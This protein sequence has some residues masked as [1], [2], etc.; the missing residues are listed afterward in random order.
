MNYQ[1]ALQKDS[2]ICLTKYWVEV[3]NGRKYLLCPPDKSPQG[4]QGCPNDTT[5]GC[6]YGY[7]FL[8]GASR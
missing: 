6:I 2:H 5:G 4:C 1:V 3:K 7:H 8:K